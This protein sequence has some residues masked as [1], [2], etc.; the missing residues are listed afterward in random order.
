MDGGGRFLKP[1]TA[2]WARRAAVPALAGGAA[3]Y[4]APSRP[5]LP[6]RRRPPRHRMGLSPLERAALRLPRFTGVLLLAGLMGAVGLYGAIRGGQ[7]DDFVARQGDPRDLVARAV[8]FGIRQV[9]ISGISELDKTEVLQVAGVESRGSLP[10]FNAAAARERLLAVPLVKTASVRKLYPDELE[11]AVTER[12]PYALW[13]S[14]GDVFVVSADGT[15]IDRLNDVRFIRL[16]LVVGEGAA[17]RATAFVKLMEGAPELRSRVRA[18]MLVGNRRWTLKLDNG[19]EVRL[20]EEGAADALV[21]FVRL[22]RED[23]ILERDLLS[24][25]MRYPDRVVLRLSEEAADA[26]A[27]ALKSKAKAK[28]SAI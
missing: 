8:G 23:K 28:G 15:V 1:L 21:R 5:S 16:P 17:A 11:I 26:R 7:Y 25:D 18:G 14:H 12:E 9:T 2:P 13:Q 22:V 10:F 19:V 20:P 24:I 4:F 27:E 3:S 6:A